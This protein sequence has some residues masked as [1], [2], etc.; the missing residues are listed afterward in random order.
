MGELLGSYGLFDAAPGGIGVIAIK[1]TGVAGGT[2]KVGETATYLGNRGKTGVKLGG[3]SPATT[4][5]SLDFAGSGFIT[6][7]LFFVD[8]N[9]GYVR[10]S[11]IQAEFTTAAANFAVGL[12]KRT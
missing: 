3:L 2:R 5:V 12:R 8:A 9:T 10:G 1:T 7:P 11:S 4:T 6:G